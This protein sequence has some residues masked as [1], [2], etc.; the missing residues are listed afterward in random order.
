M[1][2]SF[3][4]LGLPLPACCDVRPALIVG[5]VP[6]PQGAIDAILERMA[7]EGDLVRERLTESAVERQLCDAVLGRLRQ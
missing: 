2:I 7:E 3:Q 4:A 5:N 6:A 1:S